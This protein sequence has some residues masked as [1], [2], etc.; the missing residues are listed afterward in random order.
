MP[1]LFSNKVVI[2]F[3]A[4]GEAENANDGEADRPN[5][6]SGKQVSTGSEPEKDNQPEKDAQQEKDAHSDKDEKTGVE[7]TSPIASSQPPLSQILSQE[8]L[9]Q[10]R[11][12][13]MSGKLR[14]H[15]FMTL[16]RS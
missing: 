7:V 13:K 12:S 16:G 15:A 1:A 8:I 11:G 10:F 14:A 5:K 3:K 9:S 6:D 4:D 2:K